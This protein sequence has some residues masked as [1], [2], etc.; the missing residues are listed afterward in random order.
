MKLR[1]ILIAIIFTCCVSFSEAQNFKN[2]DQV[3][4]IGLGLESNLFFGTGYTSNTFSMSAS[5]EVGIKDH[6]GDEGV[7]GV[8]GFLGYTT[9]KNYFL[10]G[11]YGWK[12]SSLI[13]GGR[14]AFHYPLAYNKKLD[15]YGGLILGYNIMSATPIGVTNNLSPES[16]RPVLSIFV[17]ARYYFN[18]NISGMAEVGYGIN[19]L[20]I[21]IG[22]KL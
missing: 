21:G 14:G 12:Y 15:T 3:I 19:F 10:G 9:A 17:G 4:N 11:D 8:G 16:S 6:V 2:N 1:S 13:I 18:D 7:I 20:T 22:I 5:Y